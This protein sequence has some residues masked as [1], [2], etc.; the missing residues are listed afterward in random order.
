MDFILICKKLIWTQF[1][2]KRGKTFVLVLSPE[3]GNLLLRGTAVLYI[4]LPI[5]R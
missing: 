5:N 4:Y 3:G 1:D 2:S